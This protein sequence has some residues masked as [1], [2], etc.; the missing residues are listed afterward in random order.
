MNVTNASSAGKTGKLDKRKHE[1]PGWLKSDNEWKPKQE[2]QKKG[3]CEYM[4]VDQKRWAMSSMALHL[5]HSSKDVRHSRHDC[6]SDMRPRQPRPRIRERPTSICV[7]G[8]WG[9]RHCDGT[10]PPSVN[11]RC[12]RRSRRRRHI[13]VSRCRGGGG[14]GGRGSSGTVRGGRWSCKS[15]RSKCRWCLRRRCERPFQSSRSRSW[16]CSWDQT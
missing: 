2:K 13:C 3:A 4:R 15:S 1:Q 11:V 5:G 16:G 9:F 14:P 6:R 8:G 10:V 7:T 12:H